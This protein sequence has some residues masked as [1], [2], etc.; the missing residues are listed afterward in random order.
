MKFSLYLNIFWVNTVNMLSI[1][2]KL[3]RSYQVC[4]KNLS[5]FCI[6]VYYFIDQWVGIKS[7]FWRVSYGGRPHPA[8][9]TF[10]IL[11]EIFLLCWRYTHKFDRDVKNLCRKMEN[12]GLY[13]TYLYGYI[14]HYVKEFCKWH[15]YVNNTQIWP[16]C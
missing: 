9:A 15:L 10:R 14:Y 2:T 4:M 6:V 11:G 16:W 7:A 12:F 1:C 8:P 5:G 13:D 3:T